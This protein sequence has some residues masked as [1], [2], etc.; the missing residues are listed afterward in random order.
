MCRIVVF[1]MT[2]ALLSGCSIFNPYESEFPCKDVYK[3]KCVSAQQAYTESLSGQDGGKAE[4]SEKGEKKSD[5]ECDGENCRSA[6]EESGKP[7]ETPETQNY[8]QYKA[9][10]YKR[11]G[12]LLNEPSTP[13]VV[14]PKIMRVLLLPYKGQEGEFYMLRHVYFFVD[15]PRWILGDSTEDSIGDE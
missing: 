14:P 5:K 8:N 13:F 4:K 3:G 15:E 7:A 9:A 12:G 2:I 1:C 11:M 10:V 6:A